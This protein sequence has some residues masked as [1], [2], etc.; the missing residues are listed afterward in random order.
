MVRGA[1]RI[2]RKGQKRP[3]PFFIAAMALVSAAIASAGSLVFRA[4]EQQAIHT[5]VIDFIVVFLLLYFR[6]WDDKHRK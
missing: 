3:G 4:T 6:P 2:K 1:F 5:A